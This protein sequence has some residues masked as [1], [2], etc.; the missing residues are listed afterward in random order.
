M[1]PQARIYDPRQRQDYFITNFTTK[2]TFSSLKHGF[3]VVDCI[4]GVD[5]LGHV[6]LL[7]ESTRKTSKKLFFTTCPWWPGAAELLKALKH[8]FN[9]LNEFENTVCGYAELASDALE[10]LL[11]LRAAF[12]AS[13]SGTWC[14]GG[15]L[16]EFAPPTRTTLAK[17][18]SW[19]VAHIFGQ[20][21]KIG[22]VLSL[23]DMRQSLFLTRPFN[24]LNYIVRK[25]FGDPRSMNTTPPTR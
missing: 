10:R 8:E 21:E 11:K 13:K 15:C 23:D 19:N 24:N 22:C 25:S 2:K 5:W 4:G 18:E 3:F 1:Q 14:I 17:A 20:P 7:T 9:P 6:P 12:G 16:A